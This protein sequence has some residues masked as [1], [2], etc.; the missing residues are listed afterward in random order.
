MTIDDAITAVITKEGGYVNDPRDAGGET[1]NGITIRTARAN[2]YTGPMR[3]MPVA[4]AREIY[5]KQYVIAPGFDKVAALSMPIAAEMVD[6]GANM[7]P[8][9]AGRFLQRLLNALNNEGRDYPELLVDGAVGP[10]TL[11]AMKT[12]LAKRGTL[13]ER[14]LLAALNALQGE[15]YVALTEGRS[16]NKAFMFGWLDRIMS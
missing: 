13:G 16:A 10:G 8:N 11:A 3:D 12:F 1:K 6:T 2:G 4:L 14:R 7:G 9:V 15:R 5:A